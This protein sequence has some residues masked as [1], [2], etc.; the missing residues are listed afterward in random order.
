MTL[1]STPSVD[2]STISVGGGLFA[3]TAVNAG[4]D[5]VYSW[6]QSFGGT[7]LNVLDASYIAGGSLSVQGGTAG[8][9]AGGHPVVRGPNPM[10]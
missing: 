9:I 5:D 8:W 4:G 6:I 1:N 10:A 3:Q 2:S 7:T